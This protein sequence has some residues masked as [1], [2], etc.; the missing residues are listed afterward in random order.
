MYSLTDYVR[1]ELGISKDKSRIIEL[2]PAYFFSIEKLEE[3]Q[4]SINKG[5]CND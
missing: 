3:A 1:E 5:D 4:S 2:E